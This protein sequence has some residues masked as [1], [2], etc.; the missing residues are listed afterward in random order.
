MGAAAKARLL[1][2]HT[3]QNYARSLAAA[4]QATPALSQRFAA[5]M[6]M[7]RAAAMAPQGDERS[8]LLDCASRIIPDL[9][10]PARA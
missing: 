6:L 10:E 7:G 1:T 2:L 3:P 4:L 9:F 5:R 8:A